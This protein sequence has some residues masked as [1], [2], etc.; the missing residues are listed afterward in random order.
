MFRRPL[1]TATVS[2][3]SPAGASTLVVV[4]V[5]DKDVRPRNSLFHYA[6][7]GGDAENAFAVDPATGDVTTVV[8]LD[9]AKVREFF[10]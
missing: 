6:I 9:R 4:S 7:V 2:E 3:S 10:N 8:Q 5:V 1:Y